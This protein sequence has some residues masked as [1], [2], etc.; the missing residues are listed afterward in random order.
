MWPQSLKRRTSTQRFLGETR[1]SSRLGELNKGPAPKGPP[2]TAPAPL[3]SPGGRAAGARL[4]RQE[5]ACV[6][7]L[8]ELL[9]A[10]GG[11]GPCRM[12]RGLG[13]GGD[14]NNAI[15]GTR[16]ESGPDWSKIEPFKVLIQTSN[17]SAE[18]G[19]EFLS[20]SQY[21]LKKEW[22]FYDDSY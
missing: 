19:I 6:R 16:N 20:T 9:G 11:R 13:G 18:H 15:Y 17:P 10:S 4:A 5:L 3:A 7:S 2:S 14:P 22:N 1:V 21:P 12:G 8:L